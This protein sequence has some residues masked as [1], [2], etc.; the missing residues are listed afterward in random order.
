MFAISKLVIQRV[1]GERH[2]GN[3]TCANKH[4]SSTWEFIIPFWAQWGDWS[5]CTKSCKVYGGG[6]PGIRNRTR[7]CLGH[8]DEI[9]TCS[10]S[11]NGESQEEPCTGDGGTSEVFCTVPPQMTEWTEWSKCSRDCGDGER[12]RSRTCV[13]GKFH[14]NPDDDLCPG[15]RTFVSEREVCNEHDCD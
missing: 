11:I 13:P 15:H 6:Q 3:Y 2:R 10:R 4:G 7:K 9:K 12:G 5:R 14:P 1:D 8:T